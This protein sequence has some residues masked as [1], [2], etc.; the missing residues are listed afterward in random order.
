MWTSSLT[1]YRGGR[2][3]L[4][5]S[6]STASCHWFRVHTS[7]FYHAYLNMLQ[8]SSVK[9]SDN[10][11]V[12]VWEVFDPIWGSI[13]NFVKSSKGTSEEECRGL[14][15]RVAHLQSGGEGWQHSAILS[16]GCFTRY[17]CS[18]ILTSYDRIMN[19]LGIALILMCLFLFISYW[20]LPREFQ[21]PATRQC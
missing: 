15:G 4:F 14:I 20:N 13:S 3:Q 1:I 7:C 19:L 2:G 10:L 6:L 17:P 9:T 18:W 11:T 5:T 12:T 16:L 21:Q 8:Q